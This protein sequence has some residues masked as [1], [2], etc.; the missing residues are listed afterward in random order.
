MPDKAKRCAVHS[1]EGKRRGSSREVLATENLLLQ[2]KWDPR[3]ATDLHTWSRISQTSSP[4]LR[5][6]PCF[7]VC[8][9]LAFW[10]WLRYSNYCEFLTF[11]RKQMLKGQR[12]NSFFPSICCHPVANAAMAARA[13]Q[14]TLGRGPSPAL[15]TTCSLA[16]V[17]GEP[18]QCPEEV[19]AP[20]RKEGAVSCSSGQEKTRLNHR[21]KSTAAGNS[22][23]RVEGW[24]P[25][26]CLVQAYSPRI[27][28][29]SF[30]CC[31]LSCHNP[32]PP[33]QR[34]KREF[35]CPRA[36]T[37]VARRH[38]KGSFCQVPAVQ[39][40]TRNSCQ[41]HQPT[42]HVFLFCNLVNKNQ[43]DKSP[44]GPA[45]NS[46]VPIIWVSALHDSQL[47]LAHAKIHRALQFSGTLHSSMLG[48]R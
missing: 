29:S 10:P 11:S 19:V 34:W 43:S 9:R 37:P 46:P 8:G 36:S 44:G 14:G 47:S 24:R 4:L 31:L 1:H 41:G 45:R 17:T 28:W 21:Q 20:A 27:L 13:S 15:A 7:H 32:P 6:C 2:N 26:E 42:A 35:P 48:T 33:P 23:N 12:L 40:G 25:D 38:C 5:G 30:R 39:L 18:S 16:R 3:K 22:S